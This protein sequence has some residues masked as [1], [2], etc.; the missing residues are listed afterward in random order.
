MLCDKICKSL[1]DRLASQY[2]GQIVQILTNVDHFEMACKELQE[3][4]V[5]ARSSSSAAGPIILRATEAFGAAKKRAEKRIFELVNS[6]IDDLVETAEYDWASTYTPEGASLYMQE[7]TR[8]LSNI[9]SSVLLGLP[10]QIKELIYFDALSHISTAVLA[11]PLD[12]TVRRISPQAATA[13]RLDVNHLVEFV[14]SLGDSTLLENLE[15]LKETV[16]LMS[17]A[18]DPAGRAEE[19]FFDAERSRRR[20]GRVDRA[21]GAE[22]LEKISQG[23]EEAQAHARALAASPTQDNKKPSGMN[24]SNFS[25]RFGV[26]KD[27]S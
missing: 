7:L 19:E 15:E 21:N 4:L 6:K 11:L 5:E 3:L 14:A 23:L 10:P 17:T 25:S 1:V 22:L 18:A 12:Q 8:Y 27:R 24:F 13:Y 26:H 2:P 9:M 20:F 16:E